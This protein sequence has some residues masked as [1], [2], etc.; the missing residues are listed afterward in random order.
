LLSGLVSFSYLVDKIS[1]SEWIASFLGGLTLMGMLQR[2]R[3]LSKSNPEVENLRV[4]NFIVFLAPV[5]LAMFCLI[6]APFANI[7][8][9]RYVDCPLCY[10]YQ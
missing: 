9:M 8:Y 4:P 2:T 5:L 1:E 3:T 10:V 6:C 7:Y